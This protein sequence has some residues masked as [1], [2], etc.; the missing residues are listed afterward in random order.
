VEGVVS[1]RRATWLYGLALLPAGGL[2]LA[3]SGFV[4]DLSKHQAPGRPSGL[5][6]WALNILPALAVGLLVYL[7]LARV[8]RAR[9]VGGGS[10]GGHVRR[11]AVLYAVALAIGVPL[12]HDASRPDF[13]SL[14]Q[15]ALWSWLVPVA[16]VV[17]DRLAFR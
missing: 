1:D 5:A 15:L 4:M 3:A 10:L 7:P 2:A 14:G 17:A 13:W 6:G 11:C 9:R 8:V 16:G 12:A